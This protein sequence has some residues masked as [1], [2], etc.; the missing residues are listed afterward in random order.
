MGNFPK[1]RPKNSK[2]SILT[3]NWHTWYLGDADFG[4]GLTFSKLWPENLFLGKF[5]PKKSKLSVL[6]EN[7]H[8]WYFD[9]AN[10]YSNISFL[11]FKTLIQFWANLGRK[12]Q[13][14]LFWWK[15]C[16]RGISKMLILI[17][18]LVFWISNPE[19]IFGQIWAGKVKA[20]YFAWKLAHTH[21]HTH[22][23]IYTHIHTQYLGDVNSYF[24][25]IFLKFQT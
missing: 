9:D 11:N 4:S 25:I 23:Y 7:W 22:I 17:L 19:P 14:Y 13:S 18:A 8:T 10:S 5:G 3:E 20:V 15:I 12:S 24:D 21:T 6:P 16:A 1:F 2:L